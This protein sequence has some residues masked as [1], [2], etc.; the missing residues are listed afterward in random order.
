MARI[1]FMGTGTLAHAALTALQETSHTIVAI[2]TQPVRTHGRGRTAQTQ[3][4]VRA[5]ALTHDVPIESPTGSLAD[6]ATHARLVTYA[7]DIIIVASYGKILP[8]M[9]LALPPHGCLNIHP[10]LLPR[11]RGATPVPAAIRA[12]DAETGV[13]II[14]MDAGMDT[15]P[16]LAQKR[17][18]LPDHIHAPALL[19]QL[20]HDGARLLADVLDDY[21]TGARHTTAQS[22][23]GVTTC[24]M[25][26]RDDGFID[27]ARPADHIYNLYRA[28][29]PW[30]GVFT[31]WK[32]RRRALR[33]KILDLTPIARA[34]NIAPGTVT[35][36]DKMLL[37]ATSDGMIRLNK[38]QMEGKSAVDA[39]SFCNGYPEFCTP[40]SEA[41]RL[42]TPDHVVK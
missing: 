18:A 37:V 35:Y 15:G 25:L 36:T 19:T 32:Q 41:T 6:P 7:P 9:T 16:I 4:A 5:W 14:A 42:I 8:E 33:I 30:P 1:V 27:W 3:D 17:C 31:V 29:D 20:A 39:R 40:S 21:L 38:L 22:T 28:Y 24:G 26:T 2:Y 34:T 13:T 12:G 10:S 11:W 23:D